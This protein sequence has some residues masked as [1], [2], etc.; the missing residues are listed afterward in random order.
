MKRILLI[1]LPFFLL[2]LSLISSMIAFDY[3]EKLEESFIY[4]NNTPETPMFTGTYYT[5]VGNLPENSYNYQTTKTDVGYELV[6]LDDQDEILQHVLFTITED[7]IV[8]PDVVS[9]FQ[10]DVT[11]GELDGYLFDLEL[12]NSKSYTFNVTIIENNTDSDEIDLAFFN[13]DNDLFHNQDLWEGISSTTFIFALLAGFTIIGAFVIR[14][15]E[16]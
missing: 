12:N 6:I 11:P 2:L 16:I 4:A 1:I 14:K 15:R 9:G 3:T 7:G 13:M 10:T 8:N 5:I